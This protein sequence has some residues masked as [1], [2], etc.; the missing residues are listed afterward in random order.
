MHSEYSGNRGKQLSSLVNLV[1][2]SP[3]SFAT[4][5]LP[6]DLEY[7]LEPHHKPWV[8]IDII[9]NNEGLI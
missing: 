8:S 6:I 4:N 7:E 9:S 5:E 3:E 2:V 1:R